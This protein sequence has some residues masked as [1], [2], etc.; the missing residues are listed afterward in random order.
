[1]SEVQT[2]MDVNVKSPPEQV[3][4]K[5]PPHPPAVKAGGMRIYQQAQFPRLAGVQRFKTEGEAD[6][7][8][9]PSKEADQ[10]KKAE[11][12]EQEKKEISGK[13]PDKG[14]VQKSWKDNMG[15]QSK[16][17]VPLS[18]YSD[19]AKAIPSTYYPPPIPDAKLKN[20]PRDEIFQNRC[21]RQP[22]GKGMQ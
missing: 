16:H 18:A 3:L 4:Y 6:A 10:A 7:K 9:L 2:Q 13:T 22:P 1:M 20:S 17:A 5:K 14:I 11:T 8:S 21:I 12:T 19:F 15:I